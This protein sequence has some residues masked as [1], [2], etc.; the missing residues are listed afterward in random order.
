MNKIMK[1]VILSLVFFVVHAFAQSPTIMCGD[2]RVAQGNACGQPG[3]MVYDQMGRPTNQ[4]IGGGQFN[5]ANDIG[6]LQQL[7][8]S[9]QA[10]QQGLSACGWTTAGAI[11]GAT[12]GSLNSAHRTQAMILAGLLGGAIGNAVCED[13]RQQ[14]QAEAMQIAQL[15]ARIRAQQMAPN[16]NQLPVGQQFAQGNPCADQ[17]RI[18][19][20][21][22]NGQVGCKVPNAPAQPGERPYQ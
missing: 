18:A 22:P 9:Q 7:L 17:G 12:L 1:S 6:L 8:A 16:P 10:G 11:A 19:V 5:M 14:A 4:M 21:M 15:Q 3:V 13:R 2:Y 20:Y